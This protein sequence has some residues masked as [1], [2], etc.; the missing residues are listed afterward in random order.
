MFSKLSSDPSS[1]P[2]IPVITS[3]PDVKP[4]PSKDEKVAESAASS[5]VVKSNTENL[6]ESR[7]R[8]VMGSQS[9]LA[10]GKGASQNIATSTAVPAAESN[11]KDPDPTTAAESNSKDP[12]PTTAVESNSKDPE[13]TTAAES[14]SK[15]PEPTT[16][17]ES[18][19]KDL[20]PTTAI[21]SNSK[22]PESK[23]SIPSQPPVVKKA[24]D[25]EG[26]SMNQENNESAFVAESVPGENEG[27]AK[28]GSDELVMVED[29][30]LSGVEQSPLKSGLVPSKNGHPDV[31]ST[32]KTRQVSNMMIAYCILIVP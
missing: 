32:P 16:A 25:D 14:N 18:N 13:P 23:P 5:S 24:W 19:S 6:T 28:G 31:F 22:D 7:P 4:S 20:E 21:A 27:V 29:I 17:A 3:K 11:S 2:S 15:D 10:D 1:P 8:V 30:E 9:L 26:K 12:E